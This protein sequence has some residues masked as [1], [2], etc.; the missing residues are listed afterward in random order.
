[1]RGSETMKQEGHIEDCRVQPETTKKK[2]T[3]TKFI[4]GKHIE[5]GTCIFSKASG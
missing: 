4:K 3:K 2:N 1:M 5:G